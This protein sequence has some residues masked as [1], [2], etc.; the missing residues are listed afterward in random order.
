M[1][2]KLYEDSSCCHLGKTF[3]VLVVRDMSQLHHEIKGKVLDPKEES[4]KGGPIGDQLLWDLKTMHSTFGNNDLAL[5]LNQSHRMM[6][7]LSRPRVGKDVQLIET[8]KQI[9]QLL[10]SLSQDCKLLEVSMVKKRV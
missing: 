3:K 10:D 7:A 5:R 1:E 2:D 8:I 6:P 4:R 9:E